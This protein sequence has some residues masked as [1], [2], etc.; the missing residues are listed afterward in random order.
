[1][2]N[3]LFM[4]AAKDKENEKR[5]IQ[6]EKIDKNEILK[7]SKFSKFNSFDEFYP[8]IQ[9]CFLTFCEQNDETCIKDEITDIDI[10]DEGEVPNEK[11]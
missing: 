7:Q 11:V 10:I 5:L 6:G 9:F 2:K 3:M 8:L 4:G 1:M